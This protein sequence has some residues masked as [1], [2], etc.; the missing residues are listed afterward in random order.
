MNNTCQMCWDFKDTW[1]LAS[2]KNTHLMETR[3]STSLSPKNRAYFRWATYLKYTLISLFLVLLRRSSKRMNETTKPNSRIFRICEKYSPK[4]WRVS[5]AGTI[6]YVRNTR[7]K[8]TKIHL[9]FANSRH[10]PSFITSEFSI[11]IKYEKI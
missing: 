4:L 2:Q 5:P 11:W 7:G 10:S 1:W 3:L 9:L 8:N 6:Y